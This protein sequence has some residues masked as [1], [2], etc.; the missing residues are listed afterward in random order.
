M[1]LVSVYGTGVNRVTGT[2]PT[3][4][5]AIAWEV[6]VVHSGI[7]GWS[8]LNARIAAGSNGAGNGPPGTVSGHDVTA[9][10]RHAER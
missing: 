4:P 5:T 9:D 2:T 10:V 1:V 7:N 8:V 3:A 6:V